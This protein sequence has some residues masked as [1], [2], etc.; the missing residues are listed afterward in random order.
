MAEALA[1]IGTFSIITGPRMSLWVF[2]RATA[3]TAVQRVLGDLSGNRGH[4]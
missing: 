1:S 2:R 3:A 4:A